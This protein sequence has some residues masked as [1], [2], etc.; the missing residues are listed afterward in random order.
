MENG[1]VTAVNCISSV[2][3]RTNEVALTLIAAERVGLMCGCVRSQ[4]S[5]LIDIVRVSSI[6]SNMVQRKA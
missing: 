6:S 3:I 4:D 1:I 2:D 5:L